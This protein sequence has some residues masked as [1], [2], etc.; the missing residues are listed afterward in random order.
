M[1][2]KS[3]V[4]IMIRS[5]IR[6]GSF[7]RLFFSLI[8]GLMA[9]RATFS[10]AQTTLN[11]ANFGARGDAVQ[12]LVNTTS[13]SVVVTTTNQLSSADIGK[14]IEVF[15][16]GTQTYGKNSYGV[17]NYGNQDLIA[18]ITN[19]VNG[20]NI[21]LDQ[22]SQLTLTNTFATYGT[23]NTVAFSNTIAAASSS[24]N[25][26][27]DIPAGVYLLMPTWH[28]TDGYAY[29]SI[30]IHRGGLHFIGQSQTNTIL[31]SRGAWQLVDWAPYGEVPVR[32]FLIEVVAPIT[33][34]YP[35]SFENLTL[36]GG[37]QQ[38]N[39]LF[40][41]EFANPVDGLG[42]DEQHSAYLTYDKGSKTG[43]ATHQ[44]IT[45]VTVQHWRG[46]MFKSIDQNTNGNL[47]VTGCSFIDGD[48]TALNIYPSLDV[49]NCLFDNLF[50][51]AEIY[52]T[53]YT[54]TSY[55]V[56]NFVTN[57][58]GNGWAWNG[59]LPTSPS[60]IMQSNTFYFNGRGYNGL[61]TT[62]ASNIQ[63]LNN[64]IHCTDYQT[65]FAIGTAGSQGSY[66]NSNIVISGNSVYAD[67]YDTQNST[68]A[69]GILTAVVS[70]GG[71]GNTAVSG[72]TITGNT[73]TAATIQNILYQGAYSTNVTFSD[74]TFIDT[75]ASFYMANGN[76]MVLIGA[77][78]TYTPYQL[79]GNPGTTNL[80]SYGKGPLQPTEFVG[81]GAVFILV[82]TNATQIPDGA[83]MRFDNST[84]TQGTYYTVYLSQ[85]LVTG[86]I[87]VTNG[88]ALTVNWNGSQWTTN[89]VADE[90]PVPLGLAIRLQ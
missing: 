10:R 62:P 23:D 1:R 35:L 75:V 31:L 27:V 47:T 50:Q 34:D 51:V 9:F 2:K 49:T 68:N 72:L 73:I 26:N 53:Y 21:Y 37:V 40:H 66:A 56:N 12:F 67:A 22:T 6:V 79:A 48:A 82:D 5:Y 24:T 30:I 86:A 4:R 77:N 8:V 15:G 90:L 39:T 57:I 13:N 74:N 83:Y 54:N 11:V 38:G 43:T 36:D 71:P 7:G 61:Q 69:A 25:V 78:N 19:V 17:T 59:G 84:N 32:G 88:Q 64:Q 3:C 16:V 87:I 33:N 28:T 18:T 70:F 41:G 45:N 60:F 76:P 46:E 42:W 58:T 81:T 85:S 20:T 89:S 55:F 29:G 80:V 52:Q 63:I 14:A 65:V 44:I